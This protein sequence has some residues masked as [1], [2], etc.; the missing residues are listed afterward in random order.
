MSTPDY[1]EK[2]YFVITKNDTSNYSCFITENKNTGKV[3]INYRNTPNGKTPAIIAAGDSA[4][5]EEKALPQY[6][7][8]KLTYNGQIEEIRLIMKRASKDYNFSKLH[9][10]RL[11]MSSIKGL[12][13][14]LLKQYIT[15]YG[16]N[17]GSGSNQKAVELIENSQVTADLKSILSQYSVTIDDI[18]IDGLAYYPP[19]YPKPGEPKMLLDGMVI[20]SMTTIR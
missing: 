10:L 20:F 13:Q 5:V 1:I 16:E 19:Q 4:A 15:K 11:M 2:E 8:H 7:N 17:F 9:F 6:S 3:S 12:P 14:N 18:S